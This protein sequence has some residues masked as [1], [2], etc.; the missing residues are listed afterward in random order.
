MMIPMR[1]RIE[2]YVSA[3]RL[4]A[5]TIQIHLGIATSSQFRLSILQK[6]GT[7]RQHRTSY[8]TTWRSGRAPRRD[9]GEGMLDGRWR[10]VLRRASAGDPEPALHVLPVAINGAWHL[11]L[12]S[13]RNRN[14]RSLCQS[15]APVD[16]GSTH[17]RGLRDRTP[18]LAPLMHW[19][20]AFSVGSQLAEEAAGTRAVAKSAS[21]DRTPKSS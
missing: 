4:Q 10:E 2:R 9:R 17:T 21:A 8:D 7:F 6:A 1:R 16:S 5:W 20:A 13:P 11:T 15:L 12:T 14:R 3:A 19:S 18:R